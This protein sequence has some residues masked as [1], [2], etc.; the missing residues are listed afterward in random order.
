MFIIWRS[1]WPQQTSIAWNSF[2]LSCGLKKKKK[3]SR[4]SI[5]SGV[6]FQLWI[7][8]PL[9]GSDLGSLRCMMYSIIIIKSHFIGVCTV[10]LVHQDEMQE[11]TRKTAISDALGMRTGWTTSAIEDAVL[12]V[13]V[14][15]CASQI[16]ARKFKHVCFDAW[17]R[18]AGV[19]PI[20]RPQ[21]TSVY[22]LTSIKSFYQS[23]T[24]LWSSLQSSPPPPCYIGVILSATLYPTPP[25]LTQCGWNDAVCL[26][27]YQAL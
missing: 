26:T 5:D 11:A 1:P 24:A 21:P 6:K 9:K 10:Y 16:P 7:N 4:A 17:M 19:L 8:N 3:V 27:H 25:P 12:Q 22:L 15:N 18:T 14:T 20:V 23:A 13:S 2:P